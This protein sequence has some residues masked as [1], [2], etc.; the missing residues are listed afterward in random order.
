MTEERK[1]ECGSN[2]QGTT[3][4]RREPAG[5]RAVVGPTQWGATQ[6][7]PSSF[8]PYI[9]PPSSSFSSPLTPPVLF[10]LP[11][12]SVCSSRFLNCVPDRSKH[13]FFFFWCVCLCV[14][15]Y[16]F[17]FLLCLYSLARYVSA[18][19][20]VIYW[21]PIRRQRINDIHWIYNQFNKTWV[22]RVVLFP[23]PKPTKTKKIRRGKSFSFFFSLFSGSIKF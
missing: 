14:C 1:R 8:L 17:F 21:H 20:Q 5:P 12:T 10:S 6:T 22:V 13:L 9:S 7:P 18:F 3:R 2:T 15:V 11:P 19:C 16:L 23:C 4:R